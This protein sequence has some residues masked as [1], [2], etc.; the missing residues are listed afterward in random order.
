MEFLARLL[1]RLASAQELMFYGLLFVAILTFTGVLIAAVGFY[2]T[3]RIL[4]EMRASS[5]RMSYYLFRRFGPVEL[6]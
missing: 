2:R 5:D 1:Q 3:T 4:K 6:P